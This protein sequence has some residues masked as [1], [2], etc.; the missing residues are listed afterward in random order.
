M[1]I[2]ILAVLGLFSFSVKTFSQSALSSL[3]PL[4]LDLKNALVNDDATDASKKATALFNAINNVDT[5]SLSAKD[6]D[7]FSS[8]KAKLSYDARHI[9]EVDKIDHQREHFA[10][11][12]L[13]MYT[14]A[15]AVKLSTQPIYEEYCPMK[16]AYWLSAES[17]IKNPYF[18]NQMLTCGNVANTLQ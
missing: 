8:L 18:G 17:E 6:Q 10:S 7:I 3:L 5:K 1:K 14:L 15:K 13:N 11:L 2:L 12:S 9:S 16:K 4:Y